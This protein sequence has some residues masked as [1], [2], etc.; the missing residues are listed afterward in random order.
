M[1][2][3]KELFDRYKFCDANGVVMANGSSNKV[4]GMGTVKMKLF[5]GVFRTLD[6]GKR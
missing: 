5:D 4:I 3:N 1:C 2:A 6:D